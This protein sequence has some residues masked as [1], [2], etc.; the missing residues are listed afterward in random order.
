MKNR[1]IAYT[2]QKGGSGK[3]TTALNVSAALADKNKKVLLIDMDPQ[4]NASIGIG[5][6]VHSI[7]KSIYHVMVNPDV[8]LEDVVQQT[9][10]ENLFIAPSSVHLSGAEIEL[11]N[12]IGREKVLED[13]IHSSIDRYDFICVD[14]PPSL[15]LLTLNALTFARYVVIP[16][17]TH[18]YALEGLG[19]LINTIELIQRKLNP[20]LKILG[21]LPTLVQTNSKLS[22]AVIKE[23][24]DHFPNKVFNTRIR[25]NIKLAEA[26][27]HALSIINYAPRSHG[28]E[29]YK[30]FASELIEWSM[31]N[32]ETGC[33]G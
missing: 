26:P 31:K 10:I 9:Y 12:I 32:H 25:M 33:S 29:D 8:K 7:E 24:H 1:I 20:N 27:S 18:F 19:Q 23:L 15:G 17:Q 6:Q 13:N 28:S 11:V 2:N 21:I 3:T 30:A 22:E 4:A 5:I 16:V 14:C